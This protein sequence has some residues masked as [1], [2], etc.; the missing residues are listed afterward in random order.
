MKIRFVAFLAVV[1][2][3]VLTGPTLAQSRVQASDVSGPGQGSDISG[4][5]VGQDMLQSDEARIRLADI[6]TKLAGA[7]QEG[8][9]GIS[10]T[11][12]QQSMTVSP[13]F[14]NLFL[15][16]SRKKGR[17]AEKAFGRMLMT[18]GIPTAEAAAL[19]EVAKGLLEN[20]SIQLSQ[21][22]SALHAYNAVVDAAPASFLADPP[23]DFVALRVVLMSL[24]D[25]ASS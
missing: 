21:F 11:G 23:S 7:L 25:G 9:L 18:D 15:E 19:A 4:S 13:S 10:V 17:A 8:M 2:G 6:A 3:L 22:R 5:I 12:T 14:S 16:P 1:V 20:G 24:L